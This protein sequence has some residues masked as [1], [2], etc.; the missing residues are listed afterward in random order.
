MKDQILS[1]RIKL[2][3]LNVLLSV[4]Q[5]GSMARAADHLSVSQPV[6]SKTIAELESLLGVALLNRTSQGVEPTIYGSA[7]ARR[8]IALFNDLKTSISELEA[9]A[10]PSTG[11]LRIGTTEPMAAGLVSKIVSDLLLTHP[12]VRLH[13][14]LGD[15]PVLQ[16]RELRD[17]EIDLMIGRLPNDV[18]ADHTQL[19]VLF[20]ERAF[21]VA[22]IT[23]ELTRRRKIKLDDLRDEA[24]C[25]PP[26]RSFPGSLIGRAFEAS[27]LGVPR[28]SVSVHSVQMQVALLATGRFI[29][30]LPETMMHFSA[31]RLGLKALPVVLPIE[32]TPVA[33]VTLKDRELPPVGKLF[34]ERA[35]AI[36]KSLGK[37][38]GKH[39]I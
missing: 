20:W 9:L 7:L 33:I 36:A 13:V 25:L 10:D 3:Q 23:H 19:E 14:V 4:M 5:W 18:V 28:T 37:P 27:G 15:P 12:R 2:R 35:R 6:V 34:V 8:S 32:S 31:Q 22:G 38:Q 21:V 30:I 1:R 24:W 16:E 39:A 29:T 17:R 26:P 11:E